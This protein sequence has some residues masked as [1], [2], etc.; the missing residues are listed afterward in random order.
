MEEYTVHC[1]L[2][3]CHGAVRLRSGIGV[4][5]VQAFGSDP[6]RAIGYRDPQPEATVGGTRFVD[7]RRRREL[8]IEC[9]D[10]HFLRL[11]L[12]D[13]T[14]VDRDDCVYG[15]VE[16]DAVRCPSCRYGFGEWA[17][18]VVSVPGPTDRTHELTA[19]T[20][21]VP[22]A[23]TDVTDL[24]RETVNEYDRFA[25]RRTC[26]NCGALLAFDYDRR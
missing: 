24:S 26:P 3:T 5:Y 4:Y 19:V 12:A 13:G 20:E 7:E 15:P 17:A 6:R 23:Y 14:T 11:H 8:T 10:G 25:L 21:G 16:T 2:G 18:F 9:T 22:P 1:P